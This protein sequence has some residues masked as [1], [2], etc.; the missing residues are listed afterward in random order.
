[1][2]VRLWR[3]MRSSYRGADRIRVWMANTAVLGFFAIYRTLVGAAYRT[4]TDNFV[5]G[6]FHI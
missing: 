2:G 3:V 4:V 5:K 1:M 6:F